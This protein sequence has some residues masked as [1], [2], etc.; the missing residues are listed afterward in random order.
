MGLLNSQQSGSGTASGSITLTMDTRDV[1]I[2]NESLNHSADCSGARSVSQNDSE[3]SLSLFSQSAADP[4]PNEPGFALYETGIQATED[5]QVQSNDTTVEA[6]T[7]AT[8]SIDLD[9]VVPDDGDADGDMYNVTI[10]TSDAFNS[11]VAVTGAS[12]ETDPTGASEL[13]EVVGSPNVSTTDDDER[14]TLQLREAAASRDDGT[15]ARETITVGLE[16]DTTSRSADSFV[17]NE[18]VSY[19]I[20]DEAGNTTTT[21]AFETA[22][23]SSG[24]I[25]EQYDQNGN[26]IE[27]SELLT[28]VEDWRNGQIASSDL[29]KLIDNWRANN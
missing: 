8:Q 28:A 20:S 3:S 5:T 17:P 16:L 7:Q 1:T 19:T 11:G 18:T 15:V 10:D 14:V 12:V 24:G 22:A 25:I 13:I 23:D 9:L 4:A 29:F 6:D 21:V 26:G 2:P 27:R